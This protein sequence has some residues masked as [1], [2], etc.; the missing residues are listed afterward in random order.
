MM[1]ILHKKKTGK[2]VKNKKLILI[3]LILFSFSL[4]FT[5][6]INFVSSVEIFKTPS[7]DILHNDLGGLQGGDIGEYYHLDFGTYNDLTIVNET[8][9]TNNSNEVFLKSNFPQNLSLGD[10]NFYW[11]S[12]DNRLGIRRSIPTYVLDISGAN[13][14]LRL[15]ATS[16][17]LDFTSKSGQEWFLQI[18]DSDGRFRLYDQT[19]GQERLSID[20]NGYVGIGTS[21][22]ERDLTI[23]SSTPRPLKL[24]RDSGADTY[25]QYENT[26]RNWT[27]GL[28][29]SL[30]FVIA[31]GIQITT[32]PRF[33]IEIGGDITIEK[34]IQ[35]TPT[36]TP[37]SCSSSADEGKIYMDDSLNKPCYCDGSGWRFFSNDALCS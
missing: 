36:D 13:N 31:E 32:N 4:F 34:L 19:A 14:I 35:L 24:T 27:A 6:F 12:V 11:S 17:K 2:L 37:S 16:P 20:T 9:W 5:F 18:V 28:D 33:V 7:S 1:V 30:G 8:M 21:T 22:P 23:L 10:G 15:N 29:E 25:I 26:N 3:P